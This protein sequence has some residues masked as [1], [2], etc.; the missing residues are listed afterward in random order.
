VLRARR[1]LPEVLAELERDLP[2][3]RVW[4]LLD[5]AEDEVAADVVAR[6]GGAR[7]VRA[8]GAACRAANPL[9]RYDLAAESGLALLHAALPPE[10]K[11]VWV[12]GEA[13]RASG[14]WRAALARA[15]PAGGEEADLLATALDAYDGARNGGWYWWDREVVGKAPPLAERRKCFFPVLRLSRRLLAAVAAEHA[16]SAHQEVYLP[17][18]AHARG[19]ALA[20]IDARALG[21]RFSF[22]RAI[23]PAEWAAAPP[24]AF[25]PDLLW[26]PVK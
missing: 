13:L 8:G 3:A 12:L 1:A 14:S 9:H 23:D 11:Y 25:P 26:H 15:V 17:T 24:G 4:A 5:S 22:D 16:W 2:R 18:F 7:A 21:A 19:F 6:M 20:Q 10:I